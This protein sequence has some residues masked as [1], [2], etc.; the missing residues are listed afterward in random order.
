MPWTRLTTLLLAA[1]G[2]FHLHRAFSLAVTTDE[3][4]TAI[5]FAS[6]PWLEI[7]TSYDAN[8]HVL[9]SLLCKLSLSLF[10][11]NALALRLPSLLACLL[12]FTIAR[13]LFPGS[14]L[15]LVLCAWLAFHPALYDWFSLA[16]GYSLALAFLLAALYELSGPLPTL[17]RASI[18]LGLSAASNFVFAIPAAAVALAWTA[19]RKSW[20]RLPHLAVPGAALA[21][22]ITAIPLSRAE[23][24]NFYYGAPNLLESFRSLFAIPH[25]DFVSALLIAAVPF[26]LA[27]ALWY[28]R[29]DETLR[30]F[31]LSLTLCLLAA[32]VLRLAG[33]PFPYG[34]TGAYITLLW[35]LSTFALAARLDDASQSRL[36]V[37][38]LIPDKFLVFNGLKRNAETIASPGGRPWLWAAL[39]A[40][41]ALFV[42]TIPTGF[43]RPWQYDAGNRAVMDHLLQS[44]A[45]QPSIAASPM[46]VPGLEFYRRRPASA[47][48]PRVKTF[49]AESS[50]A[51]L[52]LRTDEPPA[53]PPA[54]YTP[55]FR[56]LVSGIV[57][58]RR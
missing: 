22:I 39:L 7:L 25:L 1:A 15:Q 30:F 19:A 3:A 29:R 5:A 56:D 55:I 32:A 27:A 31:T 45:A 47:H 33:I 14:P 52:I 42:F 57:L 46:L 9:H 51:Y 41:A 12:F 53:Q 26:T 43:A 6:P 37:F 11:W 50:P 18:F 44:G 16:R 8:H 54:G 28:S 36:F 10:G 13:R 2:A 17:T 20:T 24:A 34:R 40:P 58:F 4:F 48:W 38:R 23:G 49:T 21:L 35:I